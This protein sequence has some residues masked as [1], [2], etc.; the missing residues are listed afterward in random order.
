[1][2][3]SAF[4]TTLACVV[5]PL[6]ALAAIRGLRTAPVAV[7]T[8]RALEPDVAYAV[9]VEGPVTTLDLPTDDGHC[10]QFV[11]ASL[12]DAERSHGVRLTCESA[13]TA[14]P[15]QV[16]RWS[17]PAD[18]IAK[19][20]DLPTP[21]SPLRE[22]R[23]SRDAPLPL[24]PIV[25]EEVAVER[26]FFLHVTEG[27]LDDPA[28]YT[29]IVA[30]PV[31]RASRACVWLDRQCPFDPRL[32]RLSEDVARECD[33]LLPS[34]EA[35]VAPL[36]DVDRDGKLAVLVTPWMGN[37]QGGRTSLGG[38]VR[39]VDFRARL[40]PPLGNQA[41]VL[42]LNAAAA[43]G[44]A[45]RTLLSHELT[46]AC[47]LTPRLPSKP[48]RR[49]LPDEDDWISEGLAHLSEVAHGGWSNVDHR[50]ARFLTD[51]ARY[52]LVVSDYYHSGLWR[53]H[54]CR[55]STWLFHRWCEAT[56]GEGYV[57]RMAA[58]PHS[59]VQNVERTTGV[60][61]EDLFRGWSLSL[62]KEDVR[63]EDR[64]VGGRS[65]KGDADVRGPPQSAGRFLL[66]GPRIVRWE[67]SQKSLELSIAGTAASFVEWH[68]STSGTG[69]VA[70]HAAPS[71]K[72]QLTVIRIPKDRATLPLAVD[73]SRASS[74][75]KEI[76]GF[77][78]VPSLALRI[79][80][81]PAAERPSWVESVT[82]E[83][84]TQTEIRTLRFERPD[85]DA[86]PLDPDAAHRTALTLDRSGNPEPDGRWTTRV[87]SR[88]ATGRRRVGWLEIPVKPIA[89][90]HAAGAT[91]WK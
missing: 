14:Q 74:T 11:V 1:M 46:H 89:V 54:G 34:L 4:R 16:E 77:D 24:D 59:G 21:A 50:A 18:A 30:R 32:K 60:S 15:M 19:P 76:V 25:K 12:G 61:F 72:L 31:A 10:Y 84:F 86:G 65:S 75:P 49:G 44:P 87:V 79:D 23:T 27:A 2:R 17:L 53:N 57:S 20:S 63:S 48:G 83:R 22:P 7:G 29:R 90:V 66:D 78:D 52:P 70:F 37:L 35:H 85:L 6:L 40:A 68:P 8:R 73:W 82:L 26:A 62:L 28:Q 69:R 91:S 5:A 51:P 3:R 9:R 45:L 43:P 38:F 42:Y 39:S 36:R 81:A 55:G 67:S 58:G 41:D 64:P 88:D 56:F 13:R 47:A 71:T 80:E 33:S